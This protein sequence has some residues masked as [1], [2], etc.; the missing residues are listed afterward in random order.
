MGTNAS[1]GP[2]R[3]EEANEDTY[4]ELAS[5]RYPPPY[6]FN[7]SGLWLAWAIP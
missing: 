5:W 2:L 4:F 7:D 1:L 3:I 6:D